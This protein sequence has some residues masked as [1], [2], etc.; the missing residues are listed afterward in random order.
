MAK[1]VYAGETVRITAKDLTH[2]TSGPVT[3][4]ATVAV[5]L[6]D[7][8]GTVLSTGNAAADGDD[9][10]RDITA[11]ATA[12]QYRVGIV[13]TVSGAVAKDALFLTVKPFS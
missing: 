13:A 6:Y 4:G 8:D 1:E 7:L 3:V 12:G 10:Y 2:A 11:P 5:T 9:W